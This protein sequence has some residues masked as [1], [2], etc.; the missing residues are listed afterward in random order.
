MLAEVALDNATE[1]FTG[2]PGDTYAAVVPSLE[3]AVTTA[4]TDL[5]N[6]QTQQAEAAALLGVIDGGNAILNAVTGPVASDAA[7]ALLGTGGTDSF[8]VEVVEAIDTLDQTIQAEEDA[9]IAADDVLQANIDA[10]AQ[11]RADADTALGVRIDDEAIIRAGQDLI[12]QGN[13]DAEASTRA[14]ADTVLQ[15]NINTEATTRAAA[16]TV[17]Q[18][19]I[20]NEASTRAAADVAL[21]NRITGETTARE[22]ADQALANSINALGVAVRE[23]INSGVATAVAMSGAVFLP[24]KQFNVTMNVGAY[25]GETAFSLQGNFLVNEGFAFNAGVAGGSGSGTAARVG[26]TF[27]W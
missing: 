18:T 4:A 26:V 10:E 17:L 19:N 14:A 27:G 16:D 1:T 20:N 7:G 5:G 12:L 22:A 9:R 23:E 8:E 11:T 25:E 13:I 24:G 15:T 2:N 21:G 6:A 3:A